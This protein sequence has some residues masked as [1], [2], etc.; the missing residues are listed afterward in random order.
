MSQVKNIVHV[1]EVGHLASSLVSVA[2][3]GSTLTHSSHHTVLL[4]M[5]DLS[6]PGELWA[7]FEEILSVIRS[8]LK[9]SYD[10]KTIQELQERRITDRKKELDRG[11]DPFPMKMCIIGGRYDEFKVCWCIQRAIFSMHSKYLKIHGAMNSTNVG[12]ILIGIRLRQ[13]G[14]CWQDAEGNGSQFGREPLLLF[15]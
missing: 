6:R 11:V 1:W 3:T 15:V 10:A 8:G 5:L 2:M 9:M 14:T 7:S 4:V 12:D 13:E